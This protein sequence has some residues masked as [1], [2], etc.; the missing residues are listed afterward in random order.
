[1]RVL[2]VARQY[3]PSIGGIEN[4]VEQL[5]LHLQKKGIESEVL[6]L[7]RDFSTNEKLLN[8][9]VE[10]G[11]TVTRIPHFGS[12][13][14][15]IAFS[16]IRYLRNFD[17]IHIHAVDFF[18]DYLA[19]FKWFHR[20]P[21]ILSTHGGFFH[22]KNQYR[23]KKIYFHSVTR[24]SVQK[25]ERI[26]A[27][28]HND[29]D[30]FR[31]ISSPNLCVIEN[32]IDFETFHSIQLESV[33]RNQLVFIGRF[34]RNKRIDRLLQLVNEL[35]EDIPHIRLKIVG[36]DYDRLKGPLQEMISEF[37]INQNVEI[38]ESLPQPEMLKVIAQSRYFISASE[39]EGFGLSALEAMAA[40]KIPLLSNIPSFQKMVNHGKNGFL[41]DFNQLDSAIKTV[42]KAMSLEHQ[43][44]IAAAAVNTARRYSWD[45]VVVRFR[46]VYD[47][48]VQKEFV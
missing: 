42:K 33:N 19:L 10:N 35:K 36:K 21:I 20:K 44:K 2:Q 48:A 29:Y 37:G 24:F 30:M 39:Y 45:S 17:I 47:Q 8:R 1:M 5:A 23:L 38:L 7:D 6:T 46:E 31:T 43:E 34:S 3:K 27:S 22:T 15:P 16:T 28:S 13:R 40:G 11:V 25:A 41:L 4:F 9:S 26:V 18:I 14:Y 32:G 12:R